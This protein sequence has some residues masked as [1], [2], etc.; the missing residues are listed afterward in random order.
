MHNALHVLIIYAN[1]FVDRIADVTSTTEARGR[2]KS[3][4]SQ[5]F[6]VTRSV[7]D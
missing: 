1:Q 3:D 2:R 7:H 4:A 6:D 5:I